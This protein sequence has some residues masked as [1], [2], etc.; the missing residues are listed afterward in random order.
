MLKGLLKKIIPKPLLSLYHYCLA[1]LAAVVYHFPSKK[2]VV[3]G[4]T[5]TTGKTTTS[6]LTAQLLELAGFKV[7][8]TSTAIFKI[9]N[10]EWLNNK[11]MTMLGRFQTQKLLHQMVKTGCTYAVIETSSEGM[12]QHRHIGIHYDTLIFTNLSPEH[13]EAHGSFDNYKKT[14]LRLFTRL[15]KSKNKI[16][17]GKRIPRTIIANL[18]SEHTPDFL[19]FHVDRKLVFSINESSRGINPEPL[20]ATDIQNDI[21]GLRFKIKGQNFS[22][23]LLGKFNVYNNLGAIAFLISQDK[24]LE[25]IARLLPQTKPCPGRIELINEGQPFTVIVDYAFEPKALTGLFQTVKQFKK[26][27]AKIIT[28]TGSTGGGRDKARRPLNGQLT[29]ENSDYVIVA[30]EDPYNEDPMEIINQVAAGVR[31]K[32]KIEGK[33]FWK[34]LDRRQAISK[35]LT[36]AQENDI[37]L[38]TG[39]GCEQAMVVK[40][41]KMISWDDRKVVREELKK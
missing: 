22:S 36:L 14:K 37:V 4:V 30:N 24:R 39:K 18:D 8:L 19:N 29:A 1:I 28:L 13:L 6:Y 41:N 25:E 31:Q 9:D 5:G 34:I 20:I 23:P 10:K 15:E 27:E 33:N 35:A 26:P 38:I 12:L 2:M 17:A 11:K 21:T 16:I 40:N 32:G 7:G 3:V